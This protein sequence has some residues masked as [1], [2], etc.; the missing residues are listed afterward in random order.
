MVKPPKSRPCCILRA[1]QSGA[2]RE[3]LLITQAAGRS[4]LHGVEV[5][6]GLEFLGAVE[7]PLE[8]GSGVPGRWVLGV[9]S[10]F[11]KM[12]SPPKSL[13]LNGLSALT[14]TSHTL[15]KMG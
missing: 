15:D 14:C 11:Q 3:C 7:E 8:S 5:G 4:G 6:G 12:Q 13:P 1:Q 2:L 10:G 9:M